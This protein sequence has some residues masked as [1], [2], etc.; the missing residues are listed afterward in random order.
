MRS[1]P[2]SMYTRSGHNV[3]RAYTRSQASQRGLKMFEGFTHL[4]IHTP[5]AAIQ[6]VR[7]GSGP[8]LLVLH[9]CPQTHPMWHR[10]A[11]RLAEDFT[12]VATDLRGYGDSAKPNGGADHA[13]YWKG[14]MA[15]D[16][17]EVMSQLGFTEFFVAG[18]DRGGRVAHRMALDHPARVRKLA[19]LD[20]VPTRTM[21]KNLEQRLVTGYFHWFF[22][23]QP[24]DFPERL[25]RND[26]EYFVRSRFPGLLGPQGK[27]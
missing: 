13:A 19:V 23:I 12:V 27:I 24:F 17:V 6:L 1:L 8:P 22:L 9:G 21:F 10:V 26:P 7:G 5:E 18:H 4:T 3:Y 16:Q 25:I 20:I 11:P 15:Q 14:A 2:H